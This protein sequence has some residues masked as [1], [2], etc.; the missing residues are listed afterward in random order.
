MNSREEALE[1]FV[2]WLLLQL[3]P[4]TSELHGQM[5]HHAFTT[6]K[7]RALDALGEDA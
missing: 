1:V 3:D 4:A 6:I 2:R 5:Y 7:N